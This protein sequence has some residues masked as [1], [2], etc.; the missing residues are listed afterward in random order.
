VILDGGRLI[1]SQPIGDLGE[2]NGDLLVRVDGDVAAFAAR[3]A[4]LGIE[5]KPAAGE[6]GRGELVVQRA[7]NGDRVYDAVRDVAAELE[8]PL[9]SLRTRSRSLEDLYFGNIGDN[10]GANGSVGRG[11]D[12]GA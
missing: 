12:A 3:L 1:A 2:V 9:R 6:L 10:G 11:G 8:L 5:A 7:G 4:G